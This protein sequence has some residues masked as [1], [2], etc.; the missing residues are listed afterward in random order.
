MSRPTRYAL[1]GVI[2]AAV[3]ALAAA[4]PGEPAPGRSPYLSSLSPLA[5]RPAYAANTCNGHACIGGGHR[6]TN[7]GPLAG[8]SCNNLPH[9][10]SDQMCV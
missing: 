4:Y 10:C 7:C 8:W 2:V 9:S 3:L 6:H 1:R 5:G